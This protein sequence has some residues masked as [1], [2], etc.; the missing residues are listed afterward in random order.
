MIIIAGAG[1]NVKVTFLLKEKKHC[2][3]CNNTSTWILQ[4][5]R[6]FITLFFIPVAPYKTTYDLHC[7]I[8]GNAVNLDKET[9]NKMKINSVPYN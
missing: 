1:Y 5:A 9:F 8:C 7:P 3:H 4:K 2:F 6:H